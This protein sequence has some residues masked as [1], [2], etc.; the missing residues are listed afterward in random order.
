LKLYW[1]KLAV[2]NFRGGRGNGVD[3]GG[4]FATMPERADTV[5]VIDLI[6]FAPLLYLM[7]LGDVF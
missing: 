3:A 2:R 7:S 1:G 4:L 6:T 5:E